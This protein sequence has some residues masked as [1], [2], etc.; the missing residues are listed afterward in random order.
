M[1]ILIGKSKCF[2]TLQSSFKCP[3]ANINVMYTDFTF[4]SWNLILVLGRPDEHIV[5]PRVT[6]FFSWDQTHSHK[7]SIVITIFP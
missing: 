1:V 4:E 2:W 5:F 6:F 7:K 3:E